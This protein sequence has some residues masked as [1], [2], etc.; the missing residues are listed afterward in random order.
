[1]QNLMMRLSVTKAEVQAFS[2]IR[3]KMENDDQL[4]LPK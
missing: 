2:C 4:G 1:M 3:R